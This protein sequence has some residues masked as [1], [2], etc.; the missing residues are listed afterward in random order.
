MIN[1]RYQKKIHHGIGIIAH[2]TMANT[3]EF[4]DFCGESIPV[5]GE[6]QQTQ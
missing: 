2:S 3:P 1:T 5:A 4:S 6:K